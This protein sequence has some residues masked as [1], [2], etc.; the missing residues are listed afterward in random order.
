MKSIRGTSIVLLLSVLAL[1]PAVI[2]QDITGSISGTVTDASGAGVP[3]AKVTVTATDR[4]Q[5]VRTASTDGSGNYTAP[6]L[7]IGTYSVTVEAKGFKKTTQKD[8]AVNVNDRLTVNLTLE[9]GDV[10]TEVTVEAAPI[11]VD[12]QSAAASGLV[13]GNQVRE[14]Q[15]NTR[16]FAQLVAMVPGVS[17][18]NGDQLYVGATAPAGASTGVSFAVNGARTS[19]N[20]W[21]V[22]GA[23]NVDRG[24]NGTILNFPSIDALAEFKVL[25][26]SYSAEF[27]RSAGGQINVATKSGTNQLHGDAYEFVRNNAFAA[28]NFLNNASN[29]NLG[30]D[31]KARVPPLR[32]NN[33]GYTVGGPVWIPKVYNGKNKTFFFF[34]Q[35]FRRI[36]V[37]TTPTLTAPTADE[38]RGLFPHAVCVAASAGACTQTAT[39]IANINPVAA[40]Y[41]KDVFSGAPTA[42]TGNLL[43]PVLGN[44]YNARQELYKIDHNF[45]QKLQLSGRFLKDNIPTVEP[46]GLFQGTGPLPGVGNTT[47]NAPGKSWVIRATSAFSPSWLNEGGYNYSYGA[48]LSDPTGTISAAKSP[49]IKVTLPFTPTLLRVPAL[50]FGGG[51]SSVA[52]FGPYRDF[53]RNYNFYDNVTHI[54]GRHTLRFGFT[55]NFYQKTE[56]AGGNNA[57]TFTFSGTSLPRPAGTSVYEQAFA[58]FLLGTVGTF[59]Q[60]SLDLTPDVRT[61]QFEAY[62]Q[63]DFRVRPNLTI[64]LGVR[65]SLFKQTFDAKHMLTN[66][67]PSL[68]TAAKAPQI[69]PK[70]GNLV[71]GTGDPLNGISIN[72]QTSPFGD[73][74][75]NQDNKDFAPRIGFAWDPFGKGKTSIRAGYG[76][77]YDSILYGIFEQ[78][79]FNNPPFVNSV[80]ILNT[81]LENPAGGTTSVSLS[82]KRIRGTPVPYQTPYAQQWSF[83][84]QQQ[85]SKDALISIG[86]FGSKGTHLLGIVDINEARPGAA[87]AAGLVPAGTVFTSSNIGLINSVR[88]YLGY[89]AINSVETWFNSNYHS[90]QFSVQKRLGG[91]STINLSYTFSK[92][93]TD[94]RS[95][96]SNA[97][98]NTYNRHDGEYGLA[99]FDRRHIATINYIYE[100]PFFK[101]QP[102]LA[103]HVLGGWQLSGITQFST[104]LALDPAS[105][106]GTDPAGL[107]TVLST[108]VA[109]PRPDAVC[110]PNTGGARNQFQ[111]LNTAC[112]ADVPKGEVRPGNAG[113]GI[114]NGPGLQRW[115]MAAF[116]NIRISESA[117]FQFRAEAFNVFNHTNPNAIS[118][119]LG[120]STYGRVTSYRDPRLL[121]L[122]LKFYF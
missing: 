99:S 68:W 102:G 15:L 36:I 116:K 77:Y 101:N 88:P 11:S 32:Y 24:S 3:N 2:A 19:A 105:S 44:V 112:F 50:S 96:R 45:G 39:Q 62:V 12:L 79:I 90:M 65:Y 43:F 21:T 10:S 55:Q 117:K 87:I 97:P 6:L 63:D 57:G 108:S 35:E 60:D 53:N 110:D 56:N 76:I 109:G 86:Y 7:D 16:N 122:G 25:R 40:A 58:E 115:D 81:R 49:D 89:S 84:I 22:D 103:G 54:M 85:L 91:S 5:V 64:N 80:S 92:N 121:Q 111:W 104:G 100:L 41:L 33:F 34:S 42:G 73:K 29:V 114:I 47:T 8:I 59:T 118:V 98:Q 94:N 51:G 78:N 69:D 37:N 82:P 106:L 23:D 38:E 70:T 4:N 20:Y 14:L 67:D 46:Q 83:E 30:S 72:G 27:G 61:R 120:A 13:T 28:N 95:D 66:F 107:G 31:G 26:S 48:I 113:R 18:G 74:V 9:I 71:A 75:A 17:T 119:S 1:T 52:S 93:L